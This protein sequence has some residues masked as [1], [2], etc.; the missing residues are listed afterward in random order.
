[1]LPTDEYLKAYKE[2]SPE[3]V[4]EWHD[5]E[6]GAEGWV[7]I[8]SLRG[9]AAG[10]GTRMRKGL[11]RH[12]VESLAK[13][14]EIKFTVSGPSIGGAKAG[15]NF[16]PEDPRKDKVLHKWFKAV[17][18]LLKHYYGTGGDLN[19]NEMK[20]VIPITEE[21]GLR[22]P[23]EG[24]VNGHFHSVENKKIQQIGQLRQGVSKIL[25]DPAYSPDNSRKI[26]VADM[27]TGYG[28][29]QSVSH[30]Y[31]VYHNVTLDGKRTIIQGWGNVAASAAY[32]LAQN[33]AQIVGIIDRNSGII[34]DEGLNFAQVKDLFL[35]SEHN[36]L[37]ADDLLPFED[38]NQKI[39]DLDADIF[40]PAASSRLVS[41][42]QIEQLI[43]NG[44]EVMSCGANVPFMDNDIFYGETA[45]LVDEQISLI[46]DFI[47]NCGMAR[48][49]AYL[50]Q[51]KA[52]ISD[53]A[54]FSDVSKNIRQAIEKVH[55]TNSEATHITKAALQIALRELIST[56]DNA[57]TVSS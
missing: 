4:F 57:T 53:E 23:Q 25:E 22:H 10:G 19:I 18:P 27:I 8:N 56:H 45:K 39:W 44:L 13:I 34:V 31:D 30:Y 46:P 32:Y 40:I 24:I 52:I 36:Q 33:G 7:V 12:E 37:H 49:F 54:I 21:F 29:A 5:E 11:D 43:H 2:Q 50:M 15:I 55:S 16:D 47:A 51:E 6:T 20:E 26:A 28:V 35:T 42:T 9:G 14:M 38:V 3:I 41:R 1:M 48:T 17:I